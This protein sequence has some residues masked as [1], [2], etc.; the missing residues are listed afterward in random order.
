MFIEGWWGFMN[1]ESLIAKIDLFQDFVI[2]S[3]FKRDIQDYIQ[4]IQQPQNKNLTFMKDLSLNVRKALEEMS[5]NALDNDLSILLKETKS[6]MVLNTKEKLEELDWNAEI[7]ADS[8]HQSFQ[9]ILKDLLNKIDKNEQEVS[10]INNVL[11]K[12]VDSKDF[13]SENDQALVSLIFKDRETITSLEKFADSLYY[14]NHA[15]L[16]YNALLNPGSA[17]DISLVEIQNGSID[18]I[19]ELDPRVAADLTEAVNVGLATFGAYLTRKSITKDIIESYMGNE[20]LLGLDR[21]IDELMLDNVRDSISKKIEEQY[22]GALNQKGVTCSLAID[23]IDEI[24]KVFTDHIIKGNEL[25]LLTQLKSDDGKVLPEELREKTVIVRKRLS[26]LD[27]EDRILLQEYTIKEKIKERTTRFSEN[28]SSR[29]VAAAAP[30]ESEIRDDYEEEG[31][32]NFNDS[33]E[34][35]EPAEEFE[36]ENIGS[37]ENEPEAVYADGGTEDF[38]EENIVDYE[39]GSKIDYEPENIT[40]DEIEGFAGYENEM[41]PEYKIREKPQNDDGEPVM[42]LEYRIR[43]KMNEN[44]KV[45]NLKVYDDDEDDGAADA[46]L[47]ENKK[48]ILDFI[49]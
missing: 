33:A 34:D 4:A 25:K 44:E 22:C 7:D 3:G 19:F 47:Q 27:A 11:T 42:D 38:E 9:C 41:D 40:I 35:A 26:Q 18:V 37:Y 12:Y 13:K 20:K 1:I 16:T 23:E 39:T 36:N 29:P 48:K 10:R 6:F 24:S 45:I 14:W 17:K 49:Y 46:K 2:K 15:L 28:E 8:Y 21:Q 31:V 5:D 30:F 32:A 43:K